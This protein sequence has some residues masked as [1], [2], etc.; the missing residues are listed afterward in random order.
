MTTALVWFRR[1]LRLLDNPSLQQALRQHHQVVPIYIHDPEAERPWEPGAASRWWLHHSL[2][3]LSQQLNNIGSGLILRRGTS[4]ATLQQLITETGASHVYWN[5][6]YEPAL[7]AR[8]KVIKTQLRQQGIMVSSHNASLIVEPW[9]VVKGDGQPYRVFTPFWRACLRQGLSFALHAAPDQM[10]PLPQLSSL[11]LEAL[12]LLPTKDWARGLTQNWHA[13]ETAAHHAMDIFIENG[14]NRYREGRD[15]PDRSDT[16]RLS[17]H[18]HFGEISAARLLH[19]IQT[20][21]EQEGLLPHIECWQRELGW[22]EFAHYLLYH[23][24]DT[25]QHPFD[26]RFAHMQWEKDPQGL[27]DWQRGQTGIP[28]VDAGMRELWHTGWMHNRVRMIV[29]SLLSKNLLIDWQQGARWFWDT[30]IDA[31]LAANTLGWQ[32]T[33]GC[34]ADA[35]PWF[36][37]FNPVLQGQKFDPKG[38]YVRHWLPELAALP[39]KYL[40][41]PW[42]LSDSQLLSHGVQPGISYP[43]P[44]VD[45]AHSRQR[46][47]DRMTPLKHLN[48]EGKH[49]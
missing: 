22:R 43:R 33:A 24:P 19:S 28:I 44:I 15:R 47:L 31:D 12:T 45:L 30:L 27:R 8:D 25:P 6:L 10:P 1:D 32:W 34:G 37:I 29:A 42:E 40:H 14:L 41:R 38:D 26:P 4:L 5:R 48:N 18:L 36:R 3:S 13:G 7:V 17:P 9:Q 16:S 2:Q 49:L 20:L 35:A 11:K 39:D 46:A 21:G 23:F